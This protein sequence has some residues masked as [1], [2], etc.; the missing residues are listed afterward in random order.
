MREI[1]MKISKWWLGPLLVII[2]LG[3]WFVSKRETP[4]SP[5][6]LSS[7]RDEVLHD[8]DSPVGGNPDG[9]VTLVEFYDYNCPY[10][11]QM[12]A[13]ITQAEAADPQLRL[14][15]KEWPILGSVF[16]AKAA[17]AADRQGKFVAFHRA[18]YQVRGEVDEGKTFATAASLGLD[19][20]RLKS[21][22]QDPAIDAMLKRNLALA[23]V[24]KI[25]GTPG[26]I[27]GDQIIIGPMELDKLQ[28]VI[29]NTRDGK[30]PGQA[31]L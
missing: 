23:R 12:S 27:I 29:R 11:R 18:L 17:L 16:P 7:H 5:E 20:D 1:D 22:V 10:C 24:L 14:V 30:R 13:V 31:S 9:D 26:F 15:Y 25:D 21:D 4:V 6:V 3:A 8:A 19:V 28:T 2:V